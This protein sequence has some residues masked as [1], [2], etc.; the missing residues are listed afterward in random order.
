MLKIKYFAQ[1]E[2]ISSFLIPNFFSYPIVFVTTYACVGLFDQSFSFSVYS[3]MTKNVLL[4]I[5]Y[6]LVLFSCREN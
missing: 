1:L 5:F 6:K 2:L 3:L 4:Q